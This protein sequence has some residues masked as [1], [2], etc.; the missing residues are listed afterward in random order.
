MGHYLTVHQRMLFTGYSDSPAHEPAG[1]RPGGAL[2]TTRFFPLLWF[3]YTGSDV[4][5]IRVDYYVDLQVEG[6]ADPKKLAYVVAGQ[7]YGAN[8]VP[9][10]NQAGVFRDIDTVSGGTVEDLRH[11]GLQSAFTATEKPI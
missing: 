6:H 1:A 9:Y 8:G 11:E 3:E 10:P 2:A 5:T 4:Q 7:W